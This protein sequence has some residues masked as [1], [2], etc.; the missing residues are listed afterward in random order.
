[1]DCAYENCPIKL[2]FSSNPTILHYQYASSPFVA[3]SRCSTVFYCS[4]KCAQCDWFK[5][6]QYECRCGSKNALSE[7]YV[8]KIEEASPFIKHGMF[9]YHLEGKKE[10]I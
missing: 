2:E 9:Q 7:Q 10:S 6:H 3:C 5:R 8:R 4:Q 1:M